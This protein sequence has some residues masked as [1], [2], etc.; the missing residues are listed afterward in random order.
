MKKLAGLVAA[1]S[2][3]ALSAPVGGVVHATSHPASTAPS[4]GVAIDTTG[5]TMRA[6]AQ[7]GVTL[8]AAPCTPSRTW[9]VPK[10]VTTLEGA[11]AYAAAHASD[12]ITAG[13]KFGVDLGVLVVGQPQIDE[14]HLDAGSAA[15]GVA[16]DQAQGAGA[17]TAGA[18]VSAVEAFRA[19]A[20]SGAA[21]ATASGPGT[22]QPNTC[23]TGS[24]AFT[25][26][27]DTVYN[28]MGSIQGHVNWELWYNTSGAGCNHTF[29]AAEIGGFIDG[30]NIWFQWSSINS[31]FS[32]G[33]VNCSTCYNNIPTQKYN[34]GANNT[35][36]WPLSDSTWYCTD[37][38][39]SSCDARYQ[40]TG[41]SIPT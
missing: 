35:N 25:Y 33:S 41:D 27:Y 22:I 7:D 8:I 40:H 1:L 17:D 6:T 24:N 10:T 28:K 9:I 21:P 23:S 16:F 37:V 38:S 39:G 12:A 14:T 13:C 34:F 3:A 19:S 29:Q 2:I 15:A 4:A 36:T 5:A 11:R 26:N 20:A 18:L 31:G 32:W 30:S